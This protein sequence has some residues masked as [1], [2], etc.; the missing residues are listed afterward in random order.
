[1][2]CVVAGGQTVKSRELFNAYA[3]WCEENRETPGSERLLAFRLE[4]MG[5]TNRKKMD[6]HYWIGIGLGGGA[7]PS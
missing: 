4:E 1:D 2:R 3:A 5:Y 7:L 6:G